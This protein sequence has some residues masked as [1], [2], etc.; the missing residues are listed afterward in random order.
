MQLGI[1]FLKAWIAAL[2]AL[3]FTLKTRVVES[4]VY[5]IVHV[6]PASRRGSMTQLTNSMNI[7]LAGSLLVGITFVISTFLLASGTSGDFNLTG[8]ARLFVTLAP[9]LVGLAYVIIVFRTISGTT[10]GA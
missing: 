6:A 2:V 10:R 4:H 8:L 5:H 3:L 1:N 9:I 7:I